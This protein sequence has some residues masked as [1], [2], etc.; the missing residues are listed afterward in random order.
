MRNEQKVLL[1]LNYV[2]FTL[3]YSLRIN[4]FHLRSAD[5]KL[6]LNS[7]M[8]SIKCILHVRNKN[9]IYIKMVNLIFFSIY[10]HKINTKSTKTK[11]IYIKINKRTGFQFFFS[12]LLLL[13]LVV[14]G[15]TTI[16]LV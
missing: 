12:L 11:Q 15:T 5:N 1:L 6:G 13:L 3:L 7:L 10:L 4:Y 8:L 9:D 14:V 2:P 16:T